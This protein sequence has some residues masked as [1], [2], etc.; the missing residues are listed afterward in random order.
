MIAN[1]SLLGE[2]RSVLSYIFTPITRMSE[3]AFRE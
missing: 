3:N 2:K 1:I